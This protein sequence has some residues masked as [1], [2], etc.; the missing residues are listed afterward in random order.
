MVYIIYAKQLNCNDD[1]RI[2]DY[3]YNEH[4]VTYLIH[5]NLKL[6]AGGWLVYCPQKKVELCVM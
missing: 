2:I 1:P 3:T 4:D 5:E 6:Y